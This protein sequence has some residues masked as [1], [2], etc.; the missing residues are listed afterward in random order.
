M[1]TT[2]NGWPAIPSSPSIMLRTIKIPGTTRK[3]TV[4]TA[5][6][7]LFAAYFADWQRLMPER[8][9]LNPGPTDGYN[10]RP[11]RLTEGL[12]NHSSGT[13]VDVLYS[14]VLPAD[15]KPHMTKQEK[16]ILN[17]ILDVYVTSDGHRVLA[18][19]EW[20]NHADGMHTEISQAWDRK[21][22]RNTTIHDVNEV[23]GLLKI[24]TMGVRP[25]K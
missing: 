20:W 16:A 11:S 25:V 17:S 15:G 23:I 10:Y 9:S 2:L 3:I 4:R 22:K 7:P 12:S 6:A 1:A 24:N 21:C 14:T 5:C 8:M 13:A 19:G 18:N